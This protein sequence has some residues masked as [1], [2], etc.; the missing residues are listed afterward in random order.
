MK[1]FDQYFLNENNEFD[2]EEFEKKDS[3]TILVEH[4][5]DACKMDSDEVE[6]SDPDFIPYIAD[7]I[8]VW[9]ENNK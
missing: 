4:I 7:M 6:E 9:H 3:L 8:K 2:D 1:N 5:L